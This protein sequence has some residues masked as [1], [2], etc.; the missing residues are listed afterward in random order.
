MKKIIE[1]NGK[2]YR[3]I[4]EG[5][6]NAKFI[7]YRVFD[8]LFDTIIKI[9]PDDFNLRK[10]K[11]LERPLTQFIHRE[12]KRDKKITSGDLRQAL[13]NSDF[14]TEIFGRRGI[15]DD[16]YKKSEKDFPEFMK[17]YTTYSDNPKKGWRNYNA[18]ALTYGI[19]K[20]L[21][22]VLDSFFAEVDN[23]VPE[24]VHDR[25]I[26]EMTSRTKRDMENSFETSEDLDDF[27][28]KHQ[29]SIPKS[30]WRKIDNYLDDIRDE[31]EGMKPSG[32]ADPAKKGLK[33]I[34]TRYI[35]ESAKPKYEFSEFYQRFKR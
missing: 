23:L 33:K 31:E 7:K 1:I 12:I 2:Q 8:K 15:I 32:W 6:V 9:E 16:W 34:L 26:S 24:S 19:S 13:G 3:R 35:K 22:K 29:D 30:Q 20:P 21:Y 27:I 17:K 28:T 25:R 5:K 18:G 10:F 11:S 14:Y 4:S